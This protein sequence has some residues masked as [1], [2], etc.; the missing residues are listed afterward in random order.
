MFS[1]YAAEGIHHPACHT[2]SV[3]K[4][5]DTVPTGQFGGA[6]VP[7]FLYVPKGTAYPIRGI[8]GASLP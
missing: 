2:S 7:K 3:P 6:A 5:T 1:F 8:I 4:G